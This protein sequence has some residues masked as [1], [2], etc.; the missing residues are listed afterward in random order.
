MDL[1][2]PLLLL[3]TLLLVDATGVES[4]SDLRS[5]SSITLLNADL[6]RPDRPV[7]AATALQ[8][9]GDVV[10]G[11]LGDQTQETNGRGIR[12]LS[13]TD[14]NQDGKREGLISTVVRNLSATDGRWYRLRA[15]VGA[16]GFQ[17]R[18]R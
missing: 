18:A 15:H 4:S 9:S 8:L 16:G 14:Q 10:S 5:G 13:G 6:L 3:S 17:R 11:P 12:L 7:G 2:L 1:R